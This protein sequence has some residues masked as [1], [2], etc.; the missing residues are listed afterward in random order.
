MKEIII[1]TKDNCPNCDRLKNILVSVGIPHRL[2]K[3]VTEED[4]EEA[5]SKGFKAMPSAEFGNNLISGANA[6]HLRLFK[7]YLEE[8][9]VS[10]TI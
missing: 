8:T 2:R 4:I 10:D 1:W 6:T 7:S 3:V 9:N 5:K